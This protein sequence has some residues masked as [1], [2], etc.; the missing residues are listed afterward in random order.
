LSLEGVLLRALE[1]DPTWRYATAFELVE[2]LEAI[3]LARIGMHTSAISYALG[4]VSH[5]SKALRWLK[6]EINL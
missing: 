2:A 3:D 6:R 5:L 4:N 1:L